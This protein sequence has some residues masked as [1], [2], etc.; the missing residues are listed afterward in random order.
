[1]E[2]WR[3]VR[4]YEN[5]YQ[6]SNK[7]FVK[8]IKTGKILKQRLTHNGYLYVRLSKN[9][10]GTIKNIHVLML[11]AFIGPR[12]I[13]CVCRHLDGNK[14][15][16]N[17]NN[18]RW[19]TRSENAQDSIKHGTFHIPD[20]RGSKCET[21]KLNDLQV[22]IIKKLLKDNYLTHKEIAIIFGVSAR[23]IRDIKNDKIWRHIK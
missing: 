9:G 23:N 22:S 21:S 3:N 2:T 15:N 6:I 8:N 19:G 1:M 17:I 7:T 18:L 13:N 5:I 12:P 16:N 10:L 20:N 4:G 11:E 14:L